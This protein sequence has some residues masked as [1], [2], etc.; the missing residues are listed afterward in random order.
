MKS[1][2]ISLLMFAAVLAAIYLGV[3]DILSSTYMMI[4]AIVCVIA[5]LL[6]AYKV[7]GNPLAKDHKND[8]K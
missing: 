6:F 8:D 3:F 2:F 4:F 1:V 5:S 7:L